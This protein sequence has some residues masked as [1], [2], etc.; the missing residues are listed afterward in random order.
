MTIIGLTGGF[1]TGKSFVASVFASCGARVIDADRI[2]HRLVRRG[3]PLYRRILRE[4]GRDI[5]TRGG[6]IDRRKLAGVVFADRRKRRRLE[7]IVHPAVVREIRRRIAAARPDDALVIDAP[8]LI[9]AGLAGLVD[10]LVVVTASRARQ[11]E[12]GVRKFGMTP[13]EARR[14]IAQQMPLAR[15]ARMADFVITN[16]GTK[17]ETRRKARKVWCSVWI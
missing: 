6:A 7:K 8:L 4:F 3:T 17:P 13:A 9:E 2:A 12:R 14:R 1:A 5:L 11:V 16:N 10:R 15:K